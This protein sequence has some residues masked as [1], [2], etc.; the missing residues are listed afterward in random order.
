MALLSSMHDV[1]ETS[2]TTLTTAGVLPMT[3]EPNFEVDGN[4]LLPKTASKRTTKPLIEMEPLLNEEYASFLDE[5]DDV[6]ER[7]ETDLIPCPS[8]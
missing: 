8:K 2:L 3:D 1:C 6:E 5:L 7:S 4:A